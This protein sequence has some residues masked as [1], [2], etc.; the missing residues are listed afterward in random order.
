L[1]KNRQKSINKTV[2]ANEAGNLY[3]GT[4]GRQ[5]GRQSERETGDLTNR[6]S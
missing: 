4:G 1:T 3:N 6:G 5:S 2:Q